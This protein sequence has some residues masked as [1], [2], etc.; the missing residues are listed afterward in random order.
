M[1]FF[2]ESFM[3]QSPDPSELPVPNFEASSKN[4]IIMP[5]SYK[6][7]DGEDNVG[8]TV[9]EASTIVAIPDCTETHVHEPVA[10]NTTRMEQTGQPATT[11]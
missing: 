11:D 8:T 7:I 9:E 10:R 3:F 2:A 5:R 1:S 6:S 4:T